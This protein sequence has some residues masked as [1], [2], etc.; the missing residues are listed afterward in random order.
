MKKPDNKARYR[1]IRSELSAMLGYGDDPDAISIDQAMRLDVVMGLKS[2]LDGLRAKLYRG[3]QVDVAEM[4]QL[5]DTLEKY[6]PRQP[7][8][9][10]T[11]SIFK[12]DPYQVLDE[13]AERWRQADQATR[14]DQGLSPRISDLEEAQAR[15]DDLEAELVRLRGAQ[16]HALPAPEAERAIDVPTSAITPPGERSDLPANAR[17]VSGQDNPKLRPGSQI[18]D[19]KVVPIPPQA[20]SGAETKRRADVV[21]GRRDIDYQVMNAP[22]GK[23]MPQPSTGPRMVQPDSGFFWNPGR[24]RSW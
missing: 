22:A 10:P 4:K 15:I 13:L 11:P 17:Y 2:S 12:R 1:K 9:E 5:A 8:P 24:G 14:R 21:N 18:I 20:L 16:P 23:N 19:G 7:E 6:L 3:E